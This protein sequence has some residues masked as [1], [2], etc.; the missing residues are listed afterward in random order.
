MAMRI[1]ISGNHEELARGQTEDIRLTKP[2]DFR[3]LRELIESA[4]AEKADLGRALEEVA[5]L[6]DPS[7]DAVFVKDTQGRYL[8]MSPMGA[9]LLERS[10]QEVIGQRDSG[11]FDVATLSEEVRASDQEVLR[12]GRPY[13]YANTMRVAGATLTYLSVKLPFRDSDGAVAAIACLSRNM[14][15]LLNASPSRRRRGARVLLHDVAE[16]MAVMAPGAAPLPIDTTEVD[17][18]LD[19][20]VQV[21]HRILVVEGDGQLAELLC[22]AGYDVV[23]ATNHGVAWDFLEKEGDSIDALVSDIPL[24][25]LGRRT[26]GDCIRDRWPGIA[27]LSV[28][29]SSAVERPTSHEV[30]PRTE[31]VDVLASFFSWK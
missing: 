14:T 8:Y 4:A 1:L 25:G 12:T 17:R 28:S 15:D 31:L 26:L 18:C 21:P 22:S 2:L 3:Q 7:I 19:L 10:P 5:R 20:P 16:L 23:E 13:L 9:T 24:P 30:V 11:L 6:Y 27:I 29:D